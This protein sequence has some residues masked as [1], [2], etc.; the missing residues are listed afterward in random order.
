MVSIYKSLEKSF[1]WARGS[2]SGFYRVGLKTEL[3]LTASD[4]HTEFGLQAGL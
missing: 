1:F 4:H 2:Y 3:G